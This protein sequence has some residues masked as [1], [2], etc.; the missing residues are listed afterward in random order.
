[1]EGAKLIKMK[2]VIVNDADVAK[3]VK[4]GKSVFAK[5]ISKADDIISGEEVA[6]YHKKEL[7]AV[8]SAQLSGKEMKEM[9][10]GTAVSVRAS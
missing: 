7:I 8:G 4:E 9:K 10:R 3:Y 2:K 1:M 6:V 5:F